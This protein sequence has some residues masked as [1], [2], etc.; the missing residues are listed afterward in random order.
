MQVS[1]KNVALALLVLF[2]ASSSIAYAD[3]ALTEAIKL[4][5][6]KQYRE[7]IATLS[8]SKNKRDPVLHYIL[9]NSYAAI[10]R[11]PEA[12]TEYSTCSMLHPDA[13]TASLC[14]QA[15]KQ[16]SNLPDQNKEP[17]AAQPAA[18]SP[19]STPR[20][21]TA[22]EWAN[23]ITA[24]ATAPDRKPKSAKMSGQEWANQPDG[25]ASASGQAKAKKQ[26]GGNQSF[27]ERVKAQ[28]ADL[29]SEA[30]QQQEKSKEALARASA[31]AAEIKRDAATTS[32]ELRMRRGYS[33]EEAR[34][35]IKEE[36]EARS[37]DV[38]E[39]GRTEAQLYKKA[40]QERQ[41]ALDSA[42]KN[43]HAQMRGGKG[44]ARLDPNT[45]DLYVRNYK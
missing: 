45:S 40:A 6:A 12:L 33:R 17:K 15:I 34:A 26:A 7:A 27:D 36:A 2:M 44:K 28:A 43:L 37:K 20:K 10:N 24:G 38:L 21:P 5:E 13:K 31:E 41:K 22:L 39:R 16:F 8:K 11:V 9:G 42:V 19:P 32:E 29:H 3:Q 30:A 35:E 4:Y 25:G 1:S 23:D 18:A 14:D